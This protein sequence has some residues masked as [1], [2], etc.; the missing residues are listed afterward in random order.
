MS[1][2]HLTAA[3]LLLAVVL[4]MASPYLGF[5]VAE[6][7]T[8][9]GA[10][11]LRPAASGDEPRMRVRVRDSEARPVPRELVLYGHTEADRRV[12]LEAEIEG[13]VVALPV[14]KGAFVRA[15]TIIAR[16][17]PRDRAA[18]VREAEALVRQRERDYEAARHLEAKG[19]R[20]ENRVAENLALLER[21]RARLEQARFALSRT[22]IR[23]PFAGILERR[24]VEL[25]DYVGVGDPIGVIVDLDP[26][27]IVADLPEARL[28]GVRPGIGGRARLSDGTLREGRLRYLAREADAATRSFRLEFAVPNPGF[29]FTAGS[30]ADLYLELAPV[31]AHEIAT[32]TLTLADDGRLGVFVLEAEARVRFLPVTIVRSE[33]SRSWVTGLPPRA[34]IVTTGQGFLT[35]GALVEPVA[36]EAGGGPGGGGPAS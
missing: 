28:A 2:S 11:G 14:A 5:G 23:A 18:W 10:A 6:E 8:A 27:V 21:A 3:L 1:R 29:D 19:F 35:E 34:R 24:E 25:G 26:L 30:S 22:E 31:P 13:K 20:S 15:G 32:S 16:L 12:E 7:E 17:D 36:A 33:S 4:W 9:P